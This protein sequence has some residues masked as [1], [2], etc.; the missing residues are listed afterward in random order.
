MKVNS[1]PLSLSLWLTDLQRARVERILSSSNVGGGWNDEKTT[2]GIHKDQ[3]NCEGSRKGDGG[4]RE[5]KEDEPTSKKENYNLCI[6]A[7]ELQRFWLDENLERGDRWSPSNMPIPGKSLQANWKPT[8]H[9]LASSRTNQ[10]L[11]LERKRKKEYERLLKLSSCLLLFELLL[12][13]SS[14][15]TISPHIWLSDW[16]A[17]KGKKCSKNKKEKEMKHKH[18]KLVAGLQEMR[19]RRGFELSPEIMIS[20]HTSL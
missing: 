17:K 11:S 2:V 19:K 7:A 13:T 4:A 8:K 14:Y 20:Q 6:H 12:T 3:R 9:A 18:P 15:Y 5:R 1:D 10:N 16:I